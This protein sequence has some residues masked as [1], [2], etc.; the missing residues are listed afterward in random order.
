M[1]KLL[2]KIVAICSLLAVALTVCNVKVNAEDIKKTWISFIGNTLAS[3]CEYSVE[4]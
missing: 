2:K 3:E 4:Y 1:K